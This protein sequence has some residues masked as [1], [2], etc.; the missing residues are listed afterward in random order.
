MGTTCASEELGWLAIGTLWFGAA[1]LS[2][3]NSR[4]EVTEEA[5]STEGLFREALSEYLQRS[6]FEAERILVR[7]L[8]LYPRDVEARLLLATLLRHTRRYQ[9]GLD[10]LTRLELLR[11]AERWALEIA[12]E[13]YW[14]AEARAGRLPDGST[15]DDG[16]PDEAV[17]AEAGSADVVSDHESAGPLPHQ[18]A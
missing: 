10:Q 12:S 1:V 13:K 6:W 2:A 11:D 14:I 9:E 17:S 5:V 16:A 3:H 4:R 7:L 15:S 8:H 18:A